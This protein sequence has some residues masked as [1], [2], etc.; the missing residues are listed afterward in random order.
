MRVI[1]TGSRDADEEEVTRILD[2]WWDRGYWVVVQGGCP[3][4]ADR[5]ARNWAKLKGLEVETYEADWDLNGKLAGP[6]RN[7]RMASSE[8]KALLCLAFPLVDGESKGTWGRE[9]D[10]QI[11]G[12]V[13]ECVKRQIPARI[14]GVGRSN[15]RKGQ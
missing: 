9:D 5:A 4:G 3:T 10:Q 13:R 15:E 2:D 6:I 1:V 7:I 11:G 14:W 12:C 8:P